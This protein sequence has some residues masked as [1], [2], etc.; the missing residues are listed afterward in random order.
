[1]TFQPRE[2][3]IP[4]DDLLSLELKQ[5]VRYVRQNLPAPKPRVKPEHMTLDEFAD[6]VGAKNR[7]APIN[8]EA[9]RTPRDYASKI[10]EL[11]PY[12]A[13]A[14]GAPGEA[15]LLRQTYGRRLQ[16][17]EAELEQE[18]VDRNLGLA[19][20]AGRL[21]DLED[22]LERAVPGSVPRTSEVETS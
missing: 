19:V 2:P 1:M 12:P 8:W 11:T 14:F 15:E 10:A 21:A 3:W 6:A 9:G 7:Q 13:E 17:V 5:R 20:L 16:A 4:L 22:A 18:R